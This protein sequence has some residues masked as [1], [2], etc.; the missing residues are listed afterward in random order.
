VLLAQYAYHL[1][2]NAMYSVLAAL[3]HREAAVAHTVVDGVSAKEGSARGRNLPRS[4]SRPHL[5]TL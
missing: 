1:V 3:M 4:S 5:A 2:C